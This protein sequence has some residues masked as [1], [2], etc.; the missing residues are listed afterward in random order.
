ML[1][2]ALLSV[3]IDIVVI[4]AANESAF[5]TRSRPTGTRN[6]KRPRSLDNPEPALHNRGIGPPFQLGA[7]TG[8]RSTPWLIASGS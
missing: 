6:R 4:Q 5:S 3:Y 2:L 1:A 8:S 7:G